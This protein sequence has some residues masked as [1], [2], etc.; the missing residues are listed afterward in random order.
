MITVL[1]TAHPSK[2]R[3]LFVM[4][5]IAPEVDDFHDFDFLSEALMETLSPGCAE[6][7]E[8]L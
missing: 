6:G 7:L 2:G 8:K 5:P 1:E 3:L 4:R